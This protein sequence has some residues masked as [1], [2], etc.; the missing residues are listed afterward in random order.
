MARAARSSCS[1]ITPK[2]V[3]NSSPIKFCPPEP[4][5]NDKGQL[6]L[7]G[8]SKEKPDP[9]STEGIELN[10]K[11]MSQIIAAREEKLEQYKKGEIDL[12]T[13]ELANMVT[14][15]QGMK[16]YIQRFLPDPEQMVAMEDD[17]LSD[18]ENALNAM[19]AAVITAVSADPRFKYI[20]DSI[21]KQVD[22]Q[23]EAKLIEIR[24]NVSKRN[25]S[26]N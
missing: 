17:S 14:V 6:V 23:A 9:L 25:Y 18:D 11:I 8:Q 5:V 16:D 24:N 22:Q 26:R 15:D 7:P 3:P 10:K 1:L 21:I 2:S 4:F 13:E 12:T 20:Q 19:N